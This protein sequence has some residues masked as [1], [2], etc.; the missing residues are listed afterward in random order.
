[1]N[2]DPVVMDRTEAEFEARGFELWALERR[3]DGEFIGFT[4]LH[5]VHVQA[6]FTPTVEV[7]SRMRGAGGTSSI[8]SR[9]T[10][11]NLTRVLTDRSNKDL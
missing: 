5:Q 1:M 10:S 11:G 8:E 4:G 2:S 3:D 9:A 6:P 7:G